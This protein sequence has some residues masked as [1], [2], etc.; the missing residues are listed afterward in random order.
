MMLFHG[1]CAWYMIVVE[2]DVP[3]LC[4]IMYLFLLVF[5]RVGRRNSNIAIGVRKQCL[6][7]KSLRIQDN[8]NYVTTYYNC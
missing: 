4:D 5:M 1:F 7:V 2:I 3:C 8:K 6:S